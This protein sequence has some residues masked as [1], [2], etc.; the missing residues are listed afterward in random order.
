M[1]PNSAAIRVLVIRRCLAHPNCEQ[2]VRKLERMDAR[3]WGRWW[4]ITGHDGMLRVLSQHWDPIGLGEMLPADEYDCVSGPLATLLRRG[5]TVEEV[6]ATLTE[7]RTAHLGIES[8]P[9]QDR[10]AARALMDWYQAATPDFRGA[11]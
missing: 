9:P 7:H 3:E 6:A 11:R 8:D 1:A 2:A 4:R 5:G 10:S